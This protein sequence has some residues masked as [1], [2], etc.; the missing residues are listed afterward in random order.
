MA[1][2]GSL[3]LIVL[4]F[5]IVASA[6]GSIARLF[7]KIKLPLITGFLVVGI[8]SGPHIVGLIPKSALHNLHFINNIALAFIAFAAGS[9]IY[10]KDMRSRFKSIVWMTVGQL[11]VT[12]GASLILVF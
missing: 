7:Q 1:E 2:T 11:V 6:S 4:G 8:I 10:L 5:I 3:V 9:E 12:F